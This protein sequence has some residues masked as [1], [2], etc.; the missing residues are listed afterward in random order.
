MLRAVGIPARIITGRVSTG[1]HAWNEVFWE[2]SWHMTD[3]TWDDPLMDDGS[4]I[5][6]TNGYKGC[7]SDFPFGDN[8]RYTYFDISKVELEEDHTIGG[9]NNYYDFVIGE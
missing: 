5:C 3:V 1:G 9:G 7:T 4:N 8:L 2:E 6:G